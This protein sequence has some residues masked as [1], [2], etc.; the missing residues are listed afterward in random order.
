M[1]KNNVV[2]FSFFLSAALT[3]QLH[4]LQKILSLAD[5]CTRNYKINQNDFKISNDNYSM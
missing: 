4:V 3:Q 5:I 1:R 2:L